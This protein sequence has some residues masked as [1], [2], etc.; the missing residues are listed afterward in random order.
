[1]QN[2]KTQDLIKE[3]ELCKTKTER[4]LKCKVNKA[5]I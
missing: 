4:N 3:T 1:M 5:K 2:V